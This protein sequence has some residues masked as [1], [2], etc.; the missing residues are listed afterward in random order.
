VG[1]EVDVPAVGHRGVGAALRTGQRNDSSGG[2][3]APSR[4]AEDQ[5]PF[6]G[7]NGLRLHE[8]GRFLLR[9]DDQLT[10]RRRPGQH[11]F[12]AGKRL[13]RACG[14]LAIVEIEMERLLQIAAGDERGSWPPTEHR[15]PVRPKTVSG[16]T[17]T[18]CSSSIGLQVLD[19]FGWRQMSIV[20]QRSTI[21]PP[22]RKVFN[23]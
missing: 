2:D 12:T 22:D 7:I 13:Q 5:L 10:G 15:S 14:V 3:D 6:P 19:G 16:P 11:L 8:N 21:R 18:F 9:H 20:G 4:A 17:P 1:I 23:H